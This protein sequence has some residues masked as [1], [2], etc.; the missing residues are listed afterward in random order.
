[1]SD[2]IKARICAIVYGIFLVAFTA[3]VLLDTF[4]IERVYRKVDEEENTFYAVDNDE[5]Y[6]E[7]ETTESIITENSYK[8]DHVSIEI[9]EYYEL[10][11]MIYVADVRIDDIRYLK[12]AFARNTY[13]KNITKKTSEIAKDNEA[14]LAINGDF[15]GAH[16][17]GYV[18]RN[19]VL[20]RELKDSYN[21]E[22]LVIYK[23]GTF[24]IIKEGEY[25]AK[26]LLN[27]DALQVFSFGP[28][29]VDDG[30]I[31]V[32]REDEVAVAMENNPRTAIGIIDE[33]HYVF[34]VSDGRTKE[35]VGLSLYE[36]ADFMKKLGVKTGYNLDGGGSATMYFNG[37]VINNPTTDGNTFKERSVS[38]IVFIG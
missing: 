23:D 9:T 38:D 27:N 21:Q 11:T 29:L 24:G 31:I 28:G 1:M 19:G 37:K 25:T 14:I 22:D 3:Y 8:D 34:I 17:D 10:N 13:G 36:L 30:E 4:V 6:D 12:T 20:Y 32:G 2:K 26:E 33:L 5:S 35:S 7:N 16:S 15:Y 18:I